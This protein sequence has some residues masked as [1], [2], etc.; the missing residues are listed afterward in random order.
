MKFSQYYENVRLNTDYFIDLGGP[1]IENIKV[2]LNIDPFGPER[3]AMMK[4][5]GCEYLV[6]ALNFSIL[7]ISRNEYYYVVHH[8]FMLRGYSRKADS[9]GIETGTGS[10]TMED[11]PNPVRFRCNV[12]V[13]VQYRKIPCSRSCPS[14]IQC[15]DSSNAIC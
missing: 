9:T 14:S 3:R 15:E 10:R 6:A 11:S 5:F 13:S 12:N 4:Q 2:S 7:K 8:G 1:Q